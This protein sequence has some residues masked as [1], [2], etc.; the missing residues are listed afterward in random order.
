MKKNRLLYVLP[1]CYVDTNLIEYLLNA[2][3]NHQ[4][5]CSKVV[6]R[7]NSI[8][9]DRFAVGIIDKDK[10]EMGYI[11]DCDTI[12]RTKH[13]TLMKHRDRH[14]YLITIAPAVDKFV[15]DC[16]NEQNVD[17][18]NYGL[19]GDLSKFTKESKDVTAN[20]DSRFKR[21]FAAI[22][23]NNE[24]RSLKMALKYL[25][26]NS[27]NS[28]TGQLREIFIRALESNSDSFRVL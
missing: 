27:Y 15:L 2:G 11:R 21:L 12:A 3:V 6:E 1:E 17:P 18:E 19:P 10:V 14:Q 28:D 25:C 16:A 7:L 20:S 26:E 23:A 4:H 13:L 8:F 22:K 24:I 9:K 5:C